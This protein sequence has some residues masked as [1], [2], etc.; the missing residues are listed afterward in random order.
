MVKFKIKG[1]FLLFPTAHEELTLRQFFAIRDKSKDLFD[2]LEILS[3][4]SAKR[5]KEDISIDT[6]DAIAPFIEFIH[7]DPPAFDSFLMPD[8]IEIKGKRYGVPEG[9]G[10]KSLAQKI[11]LED[12][13]R[14]ELTDV[15]LIPTA[16]AIYFHP[17]I[18]DMPFDED[19][20]QHTID[21]VME[22]RINEAFPIAYFFFSRYKKY[23]KENQENYR[24]NQLPK[25]S[26]LEL[27]DLKSSG[28]IQ[29]F[30]PFRRLF[31]L[32]LRKLSTWIMT[33]A[34]QNY[35][36]RRMKQRTKKHIKKS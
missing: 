27:I 35:S 15:D 31:V 23:L 28:D 3:G 1:E 17:D 21:L 22:C 11:C 24:T 30:A 16:L 6:F 18:D 34:L 32:A 8:S 14:K 20:L 25:N 33:P 7:Q 5:W 13:I 29:R 12:A 9:L 19:R 2:T 36:I 10:I 26:Q 4:V